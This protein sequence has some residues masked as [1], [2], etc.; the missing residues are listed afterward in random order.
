MRPLLNKTLKHTQMILLLS[1]W[2]TGQVTF[3]VKRFLYNQL[4]QRYSKELG[5]DSFPQIAGFFKTYFLDNLSKACMVTWV[6]KRF[7]NKALKLIQK[8]TRFL[9]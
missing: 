1:Q 9:L 7:L 4:N 2:P 6:S 8:E 5:K 3:K